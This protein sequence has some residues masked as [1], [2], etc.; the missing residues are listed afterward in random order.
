MPD[1]HVE[2][3]ANYALVKRP[4]TIIQI[5]DWA[6]MPSLSS[7]D[8][9][10]RAYE[11]RRYVSDIKAANQSLDKF[12]RPLEDHNRRN[13][14]D[15]YTPRL[16][17]TRGNHEERIVRATDLDPMLEGKLSIDDF[18]VGQRGWEVYPFLQ[19]VEID[20]IEYSHYFTSGVMGRPVSS[21][22]ALL[23]ERQCSATMGHVQFTDMAF[24]KKTQNIALFAGSYYQHDEDYLGPQGNDSRRQIIMKHEVKDG[25][26]D[27]MFVSLAYLKKRF[28]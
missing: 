13:P 26:Y 2:W 8:K 11:G 3:A 14:K 24:H 7:Y 6:D 20:G 9:G 23:R 5:G 25:V 12:M 17:Y 27:P 28:A 4:Q 18:E 10:K 21:A 22:A 1:E 16:V 15:L 19:V